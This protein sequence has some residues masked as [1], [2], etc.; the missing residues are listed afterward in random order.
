MDIEVTG[1]MEAAEQVRRRFDVITDEFAADAESESASGTAED[2]V[3][4]YTDHSEAGTSAPETQDA[5][6]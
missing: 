6:D 2:D 1:H 5:D 3:P 4:A